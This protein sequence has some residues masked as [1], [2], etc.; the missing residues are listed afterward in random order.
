[1]AAGA[2]LRVLVTRPDGEGTAGRLAA[3]GHEPV[4]LRLSRVAALAQ[5]AVS[6][7]SRV[8]AVAAT[9]ANALLFAA[10]ELL[11][12]LR[13][14]PFFA[15]GPATAKAAEM[16]GFGLVR[17]GPDDALGLARLMAGTEGVSPVLYLC[18][19]VRKPDFEAALAR[20]GIEV[21]SVETYDTRPAEPSPGQ[22]EA[23]LGG[24]PVHAALLFSAMA[25]EGFRRLRS[26]PLLR[27]AAVLALSPRIAE[28]AG[29]G[30]VAAAPN[31]DGLFA[32][33]EAWAASFQSR[34]V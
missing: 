6:D 1:M 3:L 22:I 33:F 12:S 17:Q 25:A 32:F 9:S 28:A 4:M 11:E 20:S 24:R 30:L 15:V 34:P 26:H 5:Q 10:P 2:G 13:K 23:A 19:R 29:G 31:E 18:G 14:K 16:A 27:Q 21:L 8:R 7:V